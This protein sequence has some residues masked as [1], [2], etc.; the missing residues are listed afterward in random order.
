M[1]CATA[2]L[3]FMP[4]GVHAQSAAK[5]TSQSADELLA[6]PVSPSVSVDNSVVPSSSAVTIDPT[7]VPD[8]VVAAPVAPAAPEACGGLWL[9]CSLIVGLTHKMDLLNQ[10]HHC[11]T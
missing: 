6:T 10:P 5:T 9:V 3:A 11:C 7:A 1:V 2:L 8:S 4:V